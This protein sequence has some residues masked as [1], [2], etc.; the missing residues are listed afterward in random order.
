MRAIAGLL[1][2]AIAGCGGGSTD[3][4]PTRYNFAIVD[5]KNQSSTAGAPTL[6]KPITAQL[7]RDP[8]GKFA[9]RMFDFLAPAI[10]YAQDIPLS[11]EPIP[12]QLVCGEESNPGEPKVVPL[13]AFT[14]LDGKAANTIQGG[15]KAG[16]YKM[17]FTAQVES[18]LPVQDST[19]VTV[20][21]GPANPNYH[22]STSAYLHSPAVV[23]PTAVQDVY[24]NA[25]AFR[26]VS[27]GRITVKGAVVGDV[28]ARTVIFDASLYDNV[29]NHI[30]E[31]RGANDVLVGRLRYTVI[32]GSD[33]QP[34][35]NWISAGTSAT[36]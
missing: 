14:L 26:I 34:Q 31:L 18:Q 25:V 10:A 9:T 2:V 6:A 35:F 20:D 33:G 23:D 19:N 16:T 11:G 17:R 12:G 36:P 1:L 15:T 28:D 30:V 7:T 22:S 32:Q 4:G 21:P 3:T 5:G 8:N 13:C 29:Q 27:D 24:G